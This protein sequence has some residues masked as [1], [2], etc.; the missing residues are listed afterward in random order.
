MWRCNGTAEIAATFATKLQ[1]QRRCQVMYGVAEV[2]ESRKVFM[3]VGH[4][5]AWNSCTHTFIRA[6]ISLISNM[7]SPRSWCSSS[8]QDRDD[9]SLLNSLILTFQVLGYL[10]AEL[11]EIELEMK[12]QHSTKVVLSYL[13]MFL[14]DKVGKASAALG[15]AQW[16]LQGLQLEY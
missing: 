8:E 9:L 3:I 4:C 6:L 12:L 16:R 13:Y 11:V 10:R 7:K 1:L 5:G 15:L 14:I 2:V